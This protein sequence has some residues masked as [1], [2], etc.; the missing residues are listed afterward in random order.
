MGGLSYKSPSGLNASIRYRYTS[1]RPANE[2]N[3]VV[4]KGYLLSDL[5]VSYKIKSFELFSRLDNLF[6]VEWN[7]AQFD[8]ESRLRAP[9]MNGHFTGHLEPNPVS[10]LHYTPGYPLTIHAGLI[11]RF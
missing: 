11:V 7:E 10:E 8:T 2:D 4:A 9:D 6:D 1:D 3:S 5:A